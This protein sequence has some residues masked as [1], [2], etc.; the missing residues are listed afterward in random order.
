MSH[1]RF[2]TFC[3]L[4]VLASPVFAKVSRDD[5]VAI[6]QRQATGRVLSVERMQQGEREVWRV[7]LVT[8]SGEIKL[9]YVDVE[10]GGP[11]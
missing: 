6:A 5:A 7:K 8:P 9:I 1:R 10:T 3:L 2:A 4:A 11:A